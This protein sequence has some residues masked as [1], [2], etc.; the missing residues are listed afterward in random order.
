MKRR[1]SLTCSLNE[2]EALL[3]YYITI[4]NETSYGSG[5]YKCIAT[6]EAKSTRISN[7]ND[8]IASAMGFAA[9][10]TLDT[11]APSQPFLM[12]EKEMESPIG[13]GVGNYICEAAFKY[14]T[15]DALIV[16]RK[17]TTFTNGINYLKTQLQNMLYLVENFFLIFQ[18]MF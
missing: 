2:A 8:D 6:L 15:K 5:V 3:L 4:R 12:L 16:S 10:G 13:G 18:F 17:L 7:L 14:S 11:S 1:V 9:S